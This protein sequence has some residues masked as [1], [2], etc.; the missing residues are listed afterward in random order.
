MYA[1][2]FILNALK[3]CEAVESCCEWFDK[4]TTNG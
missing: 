1:I 3:N 4:L 2:T